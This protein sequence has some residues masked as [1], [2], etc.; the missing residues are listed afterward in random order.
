M[1]SQWAKKVNLLSESATVAISDR[2]RELQQSGV[3]V[4]NLGSGDPDFKTPSHIVEAGVNAINQGFTHYVSSKGIPELRKAITA[5]FQRDNNLVYDPDTEVI[6]TAGSKLALFITLATII[7]PGDEV[8]YF[9]PAWVSYKPMIQMLGG[10][11][12]GVHL[13]PEDNFALDADELKMRIT[14]RTKAMI[15][16]SPNNPT[17][18]VLTQNELNIVEQPDRARPNAKRTKHRRKSRCRT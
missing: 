1:L 14:S 7:E 9:D 5:K 8:L 2:A 6:V 11:P 10:L 18:R 15:L 12:V 16:N 3:K 4:V 17:G 13:R